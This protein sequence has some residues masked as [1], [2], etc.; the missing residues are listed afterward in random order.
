MTLTGTAKRW[1]LKLKPRSIQIWPQLKKAFMSA[2]VDH[3][4]GEAPATRLNDIRHGINEFVKNYFNRFEDE[5]IAMESILDGPGC[6][7]ERA[8]DGNNLL[9]RCPKQE[10]QTFNQLVDLIK[11]EIQTEEMIEDRKKYERERGMI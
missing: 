8:E 9:A 5:L 3:T 11:G 2:F 1:Y 7:M 4:F 10:S 6:L